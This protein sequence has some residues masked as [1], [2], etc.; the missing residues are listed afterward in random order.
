MDFDSAKKF[1]ISVS[2]IYKELGYNIIDVPFDSIEKRVEY[3]IDLI[4]SFVKTKSID[5]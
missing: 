2:A 4:D 1:G 3:V 5:S